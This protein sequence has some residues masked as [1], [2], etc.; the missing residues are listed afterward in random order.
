MKN[1][2]A[3]SIFTVLQKTQSGEIALPQWQRDFAWSAQRI[4]NLFNSLYTNGGHIGVIT[5]CKESATR[6][7]N[8]FYF[9]GSHQSFTG[10]KTFILDGCQRFSSIIDVFQNYS[11]TCN[12]DAAVDGGELFDTNEHGQVDLGLVRSKTAGKDLYAKSLLPLREIDHEATRNSIRNFLERVVF[13]AE[14]ADL[15]D[16][17]DIQTLRDSVSDIAH[18]IF[19]FRREIMDIEIMFDMIPDTID[20]TEHFV[21]INTG[22]KNLQDSEVMFASVEGKYGIYLP[23]AMQAVYEPFCN[24]M[25]VKMEHE[26]RLRKGGSETNK[27]FWGLLTRSMEVIQSVK[28]HKYGENVDWREATS[29]ETIE[30]FVGEKG[31]LETTNTIM[32]GIGVPASSRYT[33]QKSLP[34]AI[35]NGVIQ[36]VDLNLPAMKKRQALVL[37]TDFAKFHAITD[38][39]Q[40]RFSRDYRNSSWVA[41]KLRKVFLQVSEGNLGEA[42]TLMS[43]LLV[44]PEVEWDESLKYNTVG[45]L[46]VLLGNGVD[47][48]TGELIDLSN[49]KMVRVVPDA[50]LEGL[51][52]RLS[53]RRCI[54]N[55]MVVNESSQPATNPSMLKKKFYKGA[56]I[57][58]E[59]S[60]MSQKLSKDARLAAY[61]TFRA[62]RKEMIVEAAQN[63]LQKIVNK[64]V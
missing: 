30:D 36:I 58:N 25:G 13:K 35:L 50:Y 12:Y 29:N 54:E 31:Y 45:L 44:A 10:K 18:E 42:K 22:G 56:L 63:E 1:Q 53:E 38:A 62:N 48:I 34:H 9:A 23:D 40:F 46:N 60:S 55:T 43:S 33:L 41:S 15:T 16:N 37:L 21:R 17:D 28:K 20:A 52:L 49:T 2:N 7:F 26:S 24:T 59:L 4:E 61:E 8:S 11:I 14:F 57:P 19:E 51:D 39:R 27:N 5:A 47:P 64:Y 32:N 6:N 3:I